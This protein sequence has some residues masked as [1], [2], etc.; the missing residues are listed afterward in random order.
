M[1]TIR[2]LSLIITVSLAVIAFQS[3]CMSKESIITE[4]QKVVAQATLATEDTEKNAT[5]VIDQVRQK[6]I[7][8]TI[9]PADAIKIIDRENAKIVQA[10][11]QL[12]D[13]VEESIAKVDAADTQESYWSALMTG[14][15]GLGERIIAPFKA[16]YGYTEKEKEKARST[17]IVLEK[18]REEI[19]RY[20]ENAIRSASTTEKNALQRKYQAIIDQFNDAIYQ[21]QLITGDVMSTSRKLFWAT[22]GVAGLVLAGKYTT[23]E[24]VQTPEQVGILEQPLSLKEK[25]A[26]AASQQQASA[27]ELGQPGLFGADI[28]QPG[29]PEGEALLTKAMEK[30]EQMYKSPTV[31][32]IATQAGELIESGGQAFVRKVDETQRKVADW[33]EKKSEELMRERIAQQKEEEARR[34]VEEEWHRFAETAIWQAE[35]QQK[36]EAAAEK[37]IG[38]EQQRFAEEAVRVKEAR[39]KEAEELGEWY[40]SRP[41][42]GLMDQVV[43]WFKGLFAEPTEK[44]PPPIY[45]EEESKAEETPEKKKERDMRAL[46]RAFGFE[47][48]EKSAT[49]Q[50]K[51]EEVQQEQ[52]APKE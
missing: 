6:L 7:A 11:Q 33:V 24:D 49:E 41:Q 30:A 44:T 17:I 29:V 4:Q 42:E 27:E 36:R 46:Y 3:N 51:V 32:R 9:K 31:Q 21:Q 47:P 22:V 2:I 43:Q 18:Q 23:S 10:K 14:A 50:P 35:R 5:H 26:R 1:K 20:Y 13:M 48:E 19:A 38:E 40:A 25:I 8:G 45:K 37:L 52:A 34:L 16:G 28:T 15:R 12:K 39:E